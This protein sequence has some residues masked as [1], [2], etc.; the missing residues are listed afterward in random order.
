[1]TPTTP[2]LSQARYGTL[3]RLHWGHPDFDEGPA[4]FGEKRTPVWNPDIN[5][6]R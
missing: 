2:D 4:A 3:L 1:V 6:R 5:A